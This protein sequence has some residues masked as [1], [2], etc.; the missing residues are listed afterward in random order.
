MF[1]LFGLVAFECEGFDHCRSVGVNWRGWW[2][3][4]RLELELE[5]RLLIVYLDRG[6][7]DVAIPR[8]GVLLQL[9]Y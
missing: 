6:L 8:E 5:L 4:W 1:A 7:L 9:I 2:V 3:V